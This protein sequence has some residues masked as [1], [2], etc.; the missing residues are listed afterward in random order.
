MFKKTFENHTGKSIVYSN[1][2][3]I[4]LTTCVTPNYNKWNFSER[5]GIDSPLLLGLRG[6][7][8]LGVPVEWGP[9]GV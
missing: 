9:G 3:S 1:I 7:A 4:L 5:P 2:N 8:G 6:G